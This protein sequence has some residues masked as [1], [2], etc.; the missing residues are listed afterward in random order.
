MKNK[1][2]SPGQSVASG[3]YVI[4]KKKNVILEAYLG[5]CVGVTL[6]D[7]EAKVGGLSHFLL[8]EPTGLD[9]PFKAG[10]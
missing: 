5:T 10:V 4:S 3:S 2:K 9:E 8:P 1:S 6:C 7:R